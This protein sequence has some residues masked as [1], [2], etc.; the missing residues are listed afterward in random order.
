MEQSTMTLKRMT[1][2]A[3]AAFAALITTASAQD[4]PTR[5]ITLIVP[6][7]AGGGVDASARLQALAIG[8][9]LGPTTVVENVGAPAGTLGSGRGAQA[10]PGGHTLLIRKSRPP[11]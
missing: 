4:W 7:A 8:E 6:F 3:A 11:G 9:G 1:L 2:A 10:P 5:P